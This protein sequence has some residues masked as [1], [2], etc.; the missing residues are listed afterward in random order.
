[1]VDDLYSPHPSAWWPWIQ[2]LNQ[3]TWVPTSS[4]MNKP[5]G[6]EHVLQL[7]VCPLLHP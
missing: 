4:A 1:M 6:I 2:M 5:S 3:T 7:S